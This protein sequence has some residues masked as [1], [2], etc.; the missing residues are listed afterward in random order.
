MPRSKEEAQEGEWTDCWNCGG[1]GYSHH[2]CGEDCCACLD[3]EPNVPCDVC[4]GKGGWFQPYP[5]PLIEKNSVV[6]G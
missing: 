3:P 2:D 4:G 1:S 5:Q 6:E